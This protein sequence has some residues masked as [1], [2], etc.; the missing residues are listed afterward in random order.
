MRLGNLWLVDLEVVTKQELRVLNIYF[1][2]KEYKD[3]MHRLTCR[4]ARTKLK[5]ERLKAEEN[6]TSLQDVNNA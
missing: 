2:K 3:L 1:P 4:I 6:N 5:D